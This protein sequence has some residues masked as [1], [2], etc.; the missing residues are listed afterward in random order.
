MTTVV[1]QALL[2][3]CNGASEV[4]LENMEVLLIP[5]YFQIK[6]AYLWLIF[7]DYW[8]VA[9]IAELSLCPD[10]FDVNSFI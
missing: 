1:F 5:F 4:T 10:L 9:V 8:L 6:M 3:G 7:L 2:H